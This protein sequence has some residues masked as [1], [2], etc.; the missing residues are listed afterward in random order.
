MK[1]GEE[2]I[3]ITSMG[4]RRYQVCK[5]MVISETNVEILKNTE[6][7]ILTL[8]TCEKGQRNKRRCVIAKEIKN[9]ERKN[10]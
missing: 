8:I 7:N 4:E 9:E 3:Y 1:N 10:L 2:I 5:N 6:E